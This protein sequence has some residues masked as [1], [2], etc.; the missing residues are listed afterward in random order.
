MKKIIL[1]VFIS[2]FS[3]TGFS[4]EIDLVEYFKFDTPPATADFIGH[5]SDST[6][7][8]RFEYTQDFTF[9]DLNTLKQERLSGPESPVNS[10]NTNYFVITD[11]TWD[12]AG[13]AFNVEISGVSF[14]IELT[15]D[16]PI[17]TSRMVSV[18]DELTQNGSS[19]VKLGFIPVNIN[20][21][22]TIKVLGFETLET[23]LAIF[24]NTLK[25]ERLISFSIPGLEERL[26]TT[27]WYHPSVGLVRS[28]EIG[29]EDTLSINAIDPPIESGIARWM[30]QND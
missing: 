2:A 26:D 10:V 11:S 28:D 29:G 22:V 27:E 6:F 1:I 19:T 30:L 7:V 17:P 9:N 3:S 13:V 25:V 24:E 15:F 8:T 21:N 5:S 18:G 20:F 4:Q 16:P 14:P 23:P 12:T